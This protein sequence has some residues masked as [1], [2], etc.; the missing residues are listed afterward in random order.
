MIPFD[1]PPVDGQT[2]AE[3]L[4]AT[5]S[6]AGDHDA[7]VFPALGYRRSYRELWAEVRTTAWALLALG[8]Q[9]GE[10]VGIWATNCPEWVV[11]QL[12]AAQMGA[13]LV[14]INPAYRANELQYVLNQADIA[15]LLL[16]DQFKT[17]QYFDLLAEV[18]PEMNTATPG[19]LRSAACPALRRIISLKAA[20][21]SGML[22]WDEFRAGADRVS[23]AEL[24][25]LQR[26]TR[27]E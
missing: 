24:E 2:F 9:P 8:V 12:A 10:H 1:Q 25:R 7:L 21:R 19:E 23:G 22:N 13:V 3:A 6:R 15:T 5:V 11:T 4:A 17:S 14:N 16:T 26:Q 27:P 18:C 20:K